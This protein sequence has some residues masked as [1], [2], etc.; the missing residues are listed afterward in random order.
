MRT[1]SIQDTRETG[2]VLGFDLR[3]LLAALGP[4]ARES[5]WLVEDVDCTGPRADELVRAA[6][7]RQRILGEGLA[8]IAEG[9]VQV[10]DGTF[11][12]FS[13]DD[14]RLWVVL[15]AVDSTSWDVSSSDDGVLQ[16]IRESFSC[17]RELGDV[18]Y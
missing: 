17:V 9:V 1:V 16:L 14:G 3:H 18:G 12:A 4:A 7:D 5:E 2:D 6:A 8:A 13:S 11:R 10:I 15:R